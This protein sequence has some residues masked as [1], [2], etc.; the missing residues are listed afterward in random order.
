MNGLY[1]GLIRPFLSLMMLKR[2]LKICSLLLLIPF[3][4]SAQKGNKDKDPPE[5]Q[6]KKL[7]ICHK[8]ETIEINESALQAHLNHGDAVGPCEDQIVYD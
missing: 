3:I 8:G 1:L 4:V 6:W 2:G 7:T 5:K